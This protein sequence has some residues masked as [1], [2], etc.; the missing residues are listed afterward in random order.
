MALEQGSQTRGVKDQLPGEGQYANLQRQTQLDAP[1][2]SAVSPMALRAR[3]QV[4]E[5]GKRSKAT[6]SAGDI[7]TAFV[8]RFTSAV[9]RTAADPDVRK[10]LFDSLTFENATTECQRP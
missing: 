6:Q 3:D 10:V 8:Q 9:H 7:Y 1:V 4:E 5:P 2:V